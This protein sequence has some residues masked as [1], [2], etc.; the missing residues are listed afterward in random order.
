MPREGEASSC[1]GLAVGDRT[2]LDRPP[3]RAMTEAAASTPNRHP[4]AMTSARGLMTQDLDY[5]PAPADPPCRV[6]VLCRFD[7]RRRAERR[8]EGCWQTA[9]P[10]MRIPHGTRRGDSACHRPAD[11]QAHLSLHALQPDP[12]L[13]AAGDGEIADSGC[14]A[15]QQARPR[16]SARAT[17]YNGTG[18]KLAHLAQNQRIRAQPERNALGW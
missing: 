17:P 2:A 5:W 7:G 4:L 10:E 16:S 9:L 14:A 15:A 13:H 12:E 8:R 11:G 3:S 1:Q 6:S 18:P